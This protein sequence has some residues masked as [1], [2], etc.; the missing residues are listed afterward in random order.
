MLRSFKNVSSFGKGVSRLFCF[1]SSLLHVI[2]KA[3][4]GLVLNISWW[5][6]I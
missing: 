6:G 5:V 3:E 1:E 2:S 4:G